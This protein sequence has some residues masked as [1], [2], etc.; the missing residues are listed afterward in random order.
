[1]SDILLSV[2][3]PTYNVEKYIVECV[4]SLVSQIRTP[5]EII[6]V[7]D[8]ST[9]GTVALIEQ[10]YAHLP[11]VK[12]ITIPNGGAGNARD[13]GVEAAKGQ[14]VFSAILMMWW[15]TALSANWLRSLSII[16]IRICFVLI[17][18]LT[19]KTN[20]KSRGRKSGTAC[21]AFSAR[22][23]SC[24]DCYKTVRILPPPGIMS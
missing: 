11:Q 2:I 7:N 18:V 17:P 1:M 23:M 12:V 4:D 3:I 20:R 5:N 6:I 24:W 15:W 13:K 14:F 16:R 9:D 21:L 10:H 22:R 19:V 8:S